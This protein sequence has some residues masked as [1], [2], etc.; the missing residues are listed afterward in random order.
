MV[1]DSLVIICYPKTNILFAKLAVY[2]IGF[3]MLLVDE[4]QKTM[5]IEM[6]AL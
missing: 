5:Q 6:G 2:N 1:F 4:N 3:K